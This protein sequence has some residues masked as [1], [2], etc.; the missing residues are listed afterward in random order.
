MLFL[1]PI[2]LVIIGLVLLTIYVIIPATKKNKSNSNTSTPHPAK[3]QSEIDAEIAAA[4]AKAAEEAS[5]QAELKRQEDAEKLEQAAANLA[6]ANAKYSAESGKSATNILQLESQLLLVDEQ[7]KYAKDLYDLAISTSNETYITNAENTYN[8]TLNDA[9]AARTR[10]NNLIAVEKQKEQDAL[11][12]QQAALE[13]QQAAA[14]AFAESELAAQQNALVAQQAAAAA[15]AAADA[16]VAEQAAQQAAAQQAAQQAAANQLAAQQ[17]AAQQTADILEAQ[18]AAA[19]LAAQQAT[20]QAEQQAALERAAALAAQQAEAAQRAAQLAAQQAAAQQAAELAAFQ[21][22]EAAKY[23]RIPGGPCSANADCISGYC[24]ND[25]CVNRVTEPSACDT[26]HDCVDGLECVNNKCWRLRSENETCANKSE[27]NGL[28][29]V[30]NKCWRLRNEYDAC[31][32][33]GQCSAGLSC[34]NNKCWKVHNEYESCSDNTDCSAGLSCK[35]NKCW[36]IHGENE[37]CLDATDCSGGLPCVNSKC[38]RPRT[39]GQACASDAECVSGNICVNKVSLPKQ[40]ITNLANLRYLMKFKNQTTGK[41]LCA[42]PYRTPAQVYTDATGADGDCQW[43]TKVED[44]KLQIIRNVGSNHSIG[45]DAVGIWNIYSGDTWPGDTKWNLLEDE[46]LKNNYYAKDYPPGV[47]SNINDVTGGCLVDDASVVKTGSS[48]CTA[49]GVANKWKAEYVNEL[50]C[51][52]NAECPSGSC[53]NNICLNRLDEWC[54]PNNEENKYCKSGVCENFKCASE[55][56]AGDRIMITSIS[57]VGKRYLYE[58]GPRIRGAS[59]GV[60]W[61][62]PATT[63]TSTGGNGSHIWWIVGVP[64]GT[65]ITNTSEVL[66]QNTSSG[67]MLVYGE[68]SAGCNAT[69]A[70]GPYGNFAFDVYTELNGQGNERWKFIE[71]TGNLKHGTTIIL[72]NKTS[73]N[74]AWQYLRECSVDKTSCGG[75]TTKWAS[76]SYTKPNVGG[77]PYFKIE[78]VE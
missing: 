74:G 19:A 55:I 62:N 8:K 3:S 75:T 38:W 39:T 54:N 65:S 58:C 15:S 17:A 71:F 21:A 66:L 11:A 37:S 28:E 69:A 35:D 25:K 48:R 22:A 78:K 10:I 36:K 60:A 50:N 16:L 26:K 51:L 5:R 57:S 45:P 44:G 9:N 53:V 7:V 20:T 6:A 56:K 14:K 77:N 47:R 31:E 4:N 52:S 76:T 18:Q 32:T 43:R 23:P 63:F 29:C 42:K 41:Y 59:N 30:D 73:Y 46:L 67:R 13:A 2:A 1:I 64:G 34:K 68:S 70:P 49:A 24:K 40:G 12:A 27:C 61:S 33:N 72:Q